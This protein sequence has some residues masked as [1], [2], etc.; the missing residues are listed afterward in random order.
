MYPPRQDHSRVTDGL[1]HLRRFGPGPFGPGLRPEPQASAG[2]LLCDNRR[3]PERVVTF[4]IR[5]GADSARNSIKRCATLAAVNFPFS[6]FMNVLS[7][8]LLRGHPPTSPPSTGRALFRS[9]S[10]L[11]VPPFISILSVMMIPLPCCHGNNRAPDC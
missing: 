11:S 6:A 3:Q 2:A 8:R 9:L 10:F 7:C 1:R 5:N 4:P